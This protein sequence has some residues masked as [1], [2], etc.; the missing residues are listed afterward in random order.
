M[1]LAAVRSLELSKAHYLYVGGSA[2][3][4]WSDPVAPGRTSTARLGII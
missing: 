4:G 1:T 3:L 2:V